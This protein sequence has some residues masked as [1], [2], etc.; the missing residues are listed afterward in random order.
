MI[1]FLLKLPNWILILLS[2]KKQIT[3]EHRKLHPPFQLMLSQETLGDIDFSTLTA[4]QFRES[5][6]EQSKLLPQQPNN[7]VVT[8]D[9]QISVGSEEIF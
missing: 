5:Y 7:K 6:L 2:R 9:H 4:D 1:N 3:L 8:E